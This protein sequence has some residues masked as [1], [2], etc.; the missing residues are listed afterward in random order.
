MYALRRGLQ[1]VALGQRLW[2]EIGLVFGG[3]T[4]LGFLFYLPFYLSFSSQAQG[5]LPNLYNPTRLSQFLLMF[6]PFLA[7]LIFLLALAYRRNPPPRRVLVQW[8]L[9]ILLLPALFLL[10]VILAGGMLPGLRQF[11]EQTLGAPLAELVPRILRLRLS[12]PGVWLLLALLLAALGALASRAWA[13]LDRRPDRTLYFALALFFTAL[14]LTYGVEFIYLRDTFGTRMNT[15]FKFYYQ[16]WVLMAVGS[17]YALHAIGARGS[18]RLRL[19]AQ[20]LLILLTLGGL[21]YPVFA[22]P[23]KA[24]NFRNPPTLDGAR[25]IAQYRPDEAAVIA[26]VRQNTPPTAV[27]LEA[28]GGSYSDFN[29]ISAHSGRATLL[30]WGG[31]E[32]QW[33]G[34]Y[35]EPGRRE[36]LIEAVYRNQDAEQIRQIVAEFGIEYLIVGPHELEKYRITPDRA[37]A[38]SLF[39]DVAFQQGEYVVYRWRGR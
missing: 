29:T 3:L 25:F 18:V 8:L 10:L 26:W 4:A 11:A 14:L 20:I 24:G 34:N 15:V 9:A 19:P 1:G 5:F 38:F 2:L 33:R 21:V 32:L 13:D 17:V 12:T 23:A 37:R 7:A 36:P 27:L 39:W 22:I 30:G 35:Q 28:P 16:A 31:H 6:G